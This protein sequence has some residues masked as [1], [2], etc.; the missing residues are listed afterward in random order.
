MMMKNLLLVVFSSIIIQVSSQEMIEAKYLKLRYSLSQPNP[1]AYVETS[2]IDSSIGDTTF[3][4]IHN[5]INQLEAQFFQVGDSIW[6]IEESMNTLLYDYSVEEGDTFVYRPGSQLEGRFIVDS[7]RSRMLKDGETY[8]HWYLRMHENF[9]EYH[10]IWVEGLGDLRL[11][12]NSARFRGVD[13]P[14]L[15]AICKSGEELVYWNYMYINSNNPGETC[16]FEFIKRDSEIDCQITSNWKLYPNPVTNI[17]NIEAEIPLEI[18]IYDAM[19]RV[20]FREI[21]QVRYDLAALEKGVYTIVLR[22][23][24]GLAVRKLLKN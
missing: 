8:R 22:S 7:I 16:D 18:I 10:L 13:G 23:D 5:E 15:A 4:S 20:C 9:S 3:F 6:A 12:W 1:F 11:G 19:G 17:L 14:E 2:Q 24:E 21:G